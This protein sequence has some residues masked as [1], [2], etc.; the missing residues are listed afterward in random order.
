M[1]YCWPAHLPG[2]IEPQESGNEGENP[3]HTRVQAH[4]PLSR[5]NLLMPWRDGSAGCGKP[6]S[7]RSHSS[8]G[9]TSFP[10]A[11]CSSGSF[12]TF[13]HAVWVIGAVCS[14]F[15][16]SKTTWISPLEPAAA[17]SVVGD[18]DHT[19]RK[20][21]AQGFDRGHPAAGDE[22]LEEVPIQR[23][24]SMAL[25]WLALRG[26][27]QALGM[28]P[29]YPRLPWLPVTTRCL[30]SSALIGCSPGYL[31]RICTAREAT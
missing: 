2:F 24:W 26:L 12:S 9:T 23:G 31:R 19:A 21:R 17:I 16:A 28:L 8:S 25:L 7:S 1:V 22:H 29:R 13:C 15:C 5:E 14:C 20:E 10:H 27:L 18:W 6:G 4:Q 11:P 3:T 30:S